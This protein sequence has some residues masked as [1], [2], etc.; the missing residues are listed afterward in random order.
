VVVLDTLVTGRGGDRIAEGVAE[1]LAPTRKVRID[2]DRLPE[3]LVQRHRHF[4][5]L[6]QACKGLD[7]IRT[8]VVVPEDKVSLG[9]ALLAAQHGIDGV[10]DQRQHA[11]AAAVIAELA[12][13][14]AVALFGRD[15]VT[16]ERLRAGAVV[17]DGH[18]RHLARGLRDAVQRRERRREDGAAHAPS[19]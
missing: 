2:D 9:G 5:G 14:H 3:L 11:G 13:A 7:P 10:A 4:D 17:G 6:L 19:R 1:V 12:A 16:R 18:A 15:V 8:A